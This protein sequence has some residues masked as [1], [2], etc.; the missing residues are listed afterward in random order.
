M[1]KWAGVVLAAG[2]GVRMKSKIPKVLHRVCGKELIRYPVDIL[3]QLGIQRIVVVVSP[4]NAVAIQGLLGDDV[5]YV[6]QPE[7]LGTGDALHRTEET[8]HGGVEH[9]L[10][11]N[12][13]VPLVRQ[14]T[15][16]QLIARHLAEA[17]DLTLLTAISAAARDLGKIRRNQAGRVIDIVEAAE[18]QLSPESAEEINVGVYCFSA[19]WLW[20]NLERIE[21]SAKGERYLTSLAAIGA[22]RGAKIQGVVTDDSSELLGVNNRLQ[23]A[24]VEAVQRQR[25]REHWMLAGVTLLDPGS[26]F[27]DA[28][29]TIGQDTVILPNT[30]LLGQTSIGEDCEIGPGSV[31]RDSK[32]GPRCRVTASV[33]EEATTE[34]DVDVGP[35]SHLRPGAYLEHGVHIG[36]FSEVKNSRFAAGAVMGHFGYV[37]DASIG[38]NVN[39]GAGMVT[40][41]YDGKDKRRTVIE[42][43][44]FIGCDTMLVAP[45]TVGAE[46]IT[47]A[48]SVVTK[49][50]PSG[51]LVVGVPARIKER[52]AKIG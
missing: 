49:D 47:G 42:A 4:G 29:V 38:A 3:L 45:V 15:V 2:Q 27:I 14:E 8:L 6:I 36:N 44:A 17:N 26:V 24:Q 1:E 41:N 9:I 11:Q 52:K 40:C 33:I 18:R 31:I 37:G 30:M 35:F 34:D 13:D 12:A 10:V 23:L 5:E 22:A 20:E 51:S 28:N 19:P 50:V 7:V 43:G 16:R 32:V 21:P 25:I 46:A 48:G 39:L